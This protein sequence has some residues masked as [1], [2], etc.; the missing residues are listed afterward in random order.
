MPYKPVETLQLE[1]R[2][3]HRFLCVP[4]IFR[5]SYPP[6]VYTSQE[7]AARGNAPGIWAV[8]QLE[9][10]GEGPKC[11]STPATIVLAILE[12]IISKSWD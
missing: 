2:G 6:Q 3:S 7:A 12:Y 8:S 9:G 5:T 4:H 1:R 11:K 10:H